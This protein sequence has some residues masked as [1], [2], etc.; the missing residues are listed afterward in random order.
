MALAF[1]HLPPGVEADVLEAYARAIDVL[2]RLGA[3]VEERGPGFDFED[4]M[5]RN[6]RIIAAEAY[7]VHRGYIEDDALDID[8]WVR[9]RM[10]AGKNVSAADYIDE[11]AQR[12]RAAARF[13]ASM[14]QCDAIVTPTLPVTA[15]A[16]DEATTPLATFTRA[17]NYLG[18]C[19]LSLPAGL[20]RA[21]LP[22]GVQLMGGP[23]SDAALMRIG[24]AFQR[25]TSWHVRT[26][27]LQSLARNH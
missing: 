14:A 4:V 9:R 7:A 15:A 19:A 10:L 8:P 22:I 17:A 16:V 1:E 21:G 18:A 20:S 6:G 2:R 11:L 3:H 25:E 23:F 26:P 13:A 5:A 27:D 12:R 24:H